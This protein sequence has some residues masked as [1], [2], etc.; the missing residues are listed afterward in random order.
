MVALGIGL[1]Q[2]ESPIGHLVVSDVCL[3]RRRH[4]TLEFVVSEG[5]HS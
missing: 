5:G 1:V 3:L 2:F 4:R